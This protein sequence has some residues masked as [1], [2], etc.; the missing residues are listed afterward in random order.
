MLAGA[1]EEI[2]KNPIVLE[3][4]RLQMISE[5]GIEHNTSTIILMPSEFIS[6]AKSVGDAAK[7]FAQKMAVETETS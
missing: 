5:V 4:R 6:F 1:A 2:S 3:L 7:E